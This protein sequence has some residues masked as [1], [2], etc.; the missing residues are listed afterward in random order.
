MVTVYSCERKKM[1]ERNSRKMGGETR[2]R[3]VI[4]SG[5]GRVMLRVSKEP[6]LDV[7]LQQH[8]A[9][10]KPIA[11][12]RRKPLINLH[13]TRNSSFSCARCACSTLLA[14]KLVDFSTILRSNVRVKMRLAGRK[15]LSWDCGDAAPAWARWL[16]CTEL[17]R[18][19]VPLN[20]LRSRNGWRSLDFL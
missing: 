17:S 1:N 14:P 16:R 3:K 13:V 7:F 8:A 15:T 4:D 18:V 11:M 12:C 10:R 5:E 2:L 20:I 9:V 6:A 19:A